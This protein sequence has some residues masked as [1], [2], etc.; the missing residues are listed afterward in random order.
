MRA[1]NIARVVGKGMAERVFSC[2]YDSLNK[3][4]DLSLD[5]EGERDD[6]GDDE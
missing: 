2:S 1:I 5:L 4:H 3:L 6:G